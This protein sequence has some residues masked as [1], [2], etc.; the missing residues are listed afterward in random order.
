[1]HQPKVIDLARIGQLIGSGNGALD[2][3]L[4]MNLIEVVRGSCGRARDQRRWL[5]V[6][7]DDVYISTSSSLFTLNSLHLSL[8]SAISSR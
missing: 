4:F 2:M 8:S 3:W 5:K 6:G 7:L 1:M